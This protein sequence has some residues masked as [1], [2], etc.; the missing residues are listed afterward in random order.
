MNK[1]FIKTGI[2]SLLLVV[3]VLFIIFLNTGQNEYQ[4]QRFKDVEGNPTKYLLNEDGKPHQLPPFSFIDQTGKTFTEKD[5]EGKV[6]IA[7]YIFTRCQTICPKM[8]SNL[9]SV[10]R[11]FANNPDVVL[12]SHTVDPEFDTVAVLNTYAKVHGALEGKW[13]FL[14]G[15]KSKLY[16]Q[17]AEGYKIVASEDATGSDAFVHSD[18][19]VLLDRAGRIRGY[20]NGTDSMQIDTLILETKIVLSELK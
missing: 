8:S 13:Y 6:V 18:R 19:V 1:N 2:L 17:A 12:L 20:Y 3:P 7:D 10:Q 14:T 5:I 4:L 16:K 15:E 11:A 9:E